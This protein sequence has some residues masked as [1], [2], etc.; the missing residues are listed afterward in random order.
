MDDNLVYNIKGWE[1]KTGD[2]CEKGSQLRPHIVWFGEPVPLMDRAIQEAITADIF[3]VIGTSLQVYPA[4][5][6]LQFVR[7][8]VPKYIIDPNM[9]A[10]SQ[11][12]NIHLIEKGGGEGM[13]EIRDVLLAKWVS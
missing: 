8:E 4:A 13:A 6:L 7:S 10:I 2:V 11:Q 9:P 3:I 12:Q 5:S 1:L